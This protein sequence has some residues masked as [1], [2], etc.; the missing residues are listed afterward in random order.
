MT[1]RPNWFYDQATSAL[2]NSGGWRIVI[3]D[4]RRA[5]T[6]EITAEEKHA[7]ETAARLLMLLNSEAAWRDFETAPRD[8]SYFLVCLESGVVSEAYWDGER[9]ELY[10]ANTDSSGY[11]DRPLE[12]PRF[13]QPLP[14]PHPDCRRT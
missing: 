3:R 2:D 9:E 5:V 8:R 1:G 11:H 6:I 7:E 14:A 10:A 13:W 12:G 4:Q